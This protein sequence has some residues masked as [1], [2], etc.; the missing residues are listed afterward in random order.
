MVIN[1]SHVTYLRH[2]CSSPLRLPQIGTYRINPVCESRITGPKIY[3][4]F[5][6]C[7]RSPGAYTKPSNKS[8]KCRFFVS[9]HVQLASNTAVFAPT[10]NFDLSGSKP[11]IGFFLSLSRLCVAQFL[12]DVQSSQHTGLISIHHCYNPGASILSVPAARKQIRHM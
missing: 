5:R 8:Q 3:E 12:T 6:T 4:F 1:A 9:A 2:S 7:H 10:V 11:L